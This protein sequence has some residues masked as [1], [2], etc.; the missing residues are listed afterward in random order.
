MLVVITYD[1]NTMDSAGARRLR[2]VAKLCERYG[3]R[4]QN[5]VFEVLV[6]TAQ[7]TTLKHELSKEIDEKMD[8]IRFYRLGNSYKNKIDF[9]GKKVKVEAGEPLLL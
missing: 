2:R 7:L 6:D 3:I 9:M 4:V 1:V 8:S 5:S